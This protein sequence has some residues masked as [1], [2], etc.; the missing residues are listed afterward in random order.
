MSESDDLLNEIDSEGQS[1]SESE[2]SDETVGI[3]LDSSPIAIV[4]SEKLELEEITVQDRDEKLEESLNDRDIPETLGT[5]MVNGLEVNAKIPFKTAKSQI[6]LCKSNKTLFHKLKN[7]DLIDVDKEKK[8]EKMT[9]NSKRSSINQFKNF[10]LYSK[11]IND[12]IIEEKSVDM[13]NSDARERR[14]NKKQTQSK[15]SSKTV[16]GYKMN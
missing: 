16:I 3:R 11:N 1:V 12:I 14:F 2:E 7:I 10:M 9:Q 6:I 15:I 13:D 5:P 8:V 4:E